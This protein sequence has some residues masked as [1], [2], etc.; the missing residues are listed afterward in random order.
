MIIH[1]ILISLL[2]S[3]VSLFT[4]VNPPHDSYL[5]FSLFQVPGCC[6]LLLLS[7]LQCNSSHQM[8]LCH[9]SFVTSVVSHRHKVVTRPSLFIRRQTG[10][11][12]TIAGNRKKRTLIVIPQSTG[13]KIQKTEKCGPSNEMRQSLWERT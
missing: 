10:L 7:L 11:F 4:S 3:L 2:S 9:K 5:P 8:L 12:K 13:Q 6:S 1:H